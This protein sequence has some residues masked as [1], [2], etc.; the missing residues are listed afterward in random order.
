MIGPVIGI[1]SERRASSSTVDVRQGGVVDSSS[2][3]KATKED[4]RVH[5]MFTFEF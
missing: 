4:W 1:H 2:T 3:G 5:G